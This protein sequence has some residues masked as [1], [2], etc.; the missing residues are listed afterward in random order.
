MRQLLFFLIIPAT[1]LSQ[2]AMFSSIRMKPL[3][4]KY[5]VDSATIVYPIVKIRN[6][7]A[8]E[9]INNSIR[10][11]LLSNINDEDSVSSIDLAI[12][13]YVNDGLVSLSYKP[14][15]NDNS[16]LSLQ[17]FMEAVG[18]YLTSWQVH[19]NFDLNTGGLITL[20]N[21]IKEEKFNV[22]KQFIFHRK[23]NFLKKYKIEIKNW[24]A[25]K[26]I[27]KEDYMS[28]LREVNSYCSDSVSLQKFILTKSY[29][30]IFDNCEFPH[31]IMGLGPAYELKFKLP[32]IKSYIKED[33]YK[34]LIH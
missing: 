6:A 16:I 23:L 12:K 19:L 15:F 24:L 33:F 1:C 34:K 21:I 29:I 17:F 28:A 9:K 2:S 31:V 10:A 7:T 32:S 22:F 18:A 30:E 25:K 27:T 26:E 8:Q 5:N 20:K 11:V 4:E 3:Q 14:L 13:S